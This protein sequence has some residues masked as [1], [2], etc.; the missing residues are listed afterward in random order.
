MFPDGFQRLDLH[1]FGFFV[2]EGRVYAL[3][4]VVGQFLQLVLGPVLVILGDLAFFTQFVD[5]LHLIAADVTH[6]DPPFLGHVAGDPDQLP[7]A[8][9]G[10]LGYGEA[11]DLAVIQRVETDIRVPYGALYVL[12]GARVERG[13]G[14]QARLGRADVGDAPQRY[15]RAVGVDLD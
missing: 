6:R 1:Q 8:L 7:A 12:E 14:E 11:Q 13:H 9:L 5:V 15:L 2:G 10:E 3:H 4:V